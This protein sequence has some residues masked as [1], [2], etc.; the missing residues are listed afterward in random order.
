MTT[1]RDAL[2][3]VTD[4]FRNTEAATMNHTSDN[5]VPAPPPARPTL[6]PQQVLE[7]ALGCTLTDCAL[8]ALA[9]TASG[10]PPGRPGKAHY[11]SPHEAGVDGQLAQLEQQLA[12]VSDRQRRSIAAA[13]SFKLMG[14]AGGVEEE[15]AAA[16]AQTSIAEDLDRRVRTIKALAPIAKREALRSRLADVVAE[17]TELR[18]K[19]DAHTRANCVP[20]ARITGEFPSGAPQQSPTAWDDDHRALTGRLEQAQRAVASIELDLA[21]WDHAN[22]ALVEENISR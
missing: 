19:I 20:A 21:A 22:P 18:E 11:S 13:A 14:L 12:E 8:H 9:M 15:A 16:Q 4:L 2:R 5:P 17:S 7:G 10:L 3:R 6:S 1:L